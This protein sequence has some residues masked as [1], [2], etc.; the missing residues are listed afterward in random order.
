MVGATVGAGVE[1]AITDNF[2]LGIEGRYSWYGT[3]RINAGSVAV[4]A[5]PGAAVVFVNSPTYRDIKLET[6]E[7][8]FKANWKLV[9]SR[10]CQV[11]IFKYCF[12]TIFVRKARPRGVFFFDDRESRCV[13]GFH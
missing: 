4:F 11:L 8:L 6:G 3:E 2:T 1:H 5:L 12:A 9:P 10:R 13:P 7:I